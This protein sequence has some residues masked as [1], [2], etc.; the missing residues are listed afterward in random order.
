MIPREYLRKI[1]KIEIRTSQLAQ[2]LLTGAYHSV[3]R[4]R[5]MDFE[6]V[7]EYQPGDDVRLIDWNVTART[8][9][10]HI[11]KY[12]EE[13][14]LSMVVL[15]DVSASDQLGSG[16][17]S[18]KEL[19]AEVAS[20]LAF[21]A[22]QNGDKIGLLLYSDEVESFIPPRKGRSHVFRIIREILY[23]RPAR[24]GTSLKAA[25][26]YLNL[27]FSHPAVIFVISDFLDEGYEKALR[28]TNQKHDVI[29]VSIFDRRELELPDVGLIALE[30]AETGEVVEVDTS[31]RALREKF[32]AEAAEQRR[33]RQQWLKRTG[34]DVIEM[35][36][37]KPYH[38]AL[39]NFF[40]K[41]IRRARR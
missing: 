22:S 2:D 41:R 28:V 33:L 16:T 29:A 11:K 36:T 40:L 23:F 8:G 13:R 19:A 10:P 21:S 9:V 35:E 26:H 7:R 17:Q 27:V 30:D 39:K 4:G 32:A 38:I 25:L 1:R 12:R 24:R 14:E 37:G 18:K 15:V 3:F 31:N 34:L 20:T 5:G 6:E